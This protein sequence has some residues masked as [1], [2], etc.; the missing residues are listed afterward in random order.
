MTGICWRAISRAM[1]LLKAISPPLQKEY[2]ASMDEPTRPASEEMFTT[3][4]RPRSL[5]R[6]STAWCMFSGP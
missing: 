1:V 4:P 6:R 5:I 3:R 2:T